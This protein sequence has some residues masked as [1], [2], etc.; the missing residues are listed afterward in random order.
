MEKHFFSLRG[1]Q[2]DKALVQTL[3]EK[4]LGMAQSK[5]WEQKWIKLI[6]AFPQKHSL[7]WF[8]QHLAGLMTDVAP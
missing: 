8:K 4:M 3:T 5:F 2:A 7:H 6:E 1:D